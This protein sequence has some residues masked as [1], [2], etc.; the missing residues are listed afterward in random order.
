MLEVKVKLTVDD[1]DFNFGITF[2]IDIIS[3]RPSLSISLNN[4]VYII[5]INVV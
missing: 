1:I 5:A 2:L 4:A 3:N